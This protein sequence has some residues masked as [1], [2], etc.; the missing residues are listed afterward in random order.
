MV[1]PRFPSQ[2]APATSAST[3]AYSVM[4][5][6]A[7]AR[8][9]RS[10]LVLT[11]LF[12]LRAVRF[13]KESRPRPA[14]AGRRARKSVDRSAPPGLRCLQTTNAQGGLT[15]GAAGQLQSSVDRFVGP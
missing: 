13:G 7:T 6:P 11:A 10:R 15:M 4:A 3:M 2:L 9:G 1:C 14:A 12:Y 8:L 5:W